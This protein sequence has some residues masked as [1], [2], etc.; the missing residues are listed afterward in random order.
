MPEPRAPMQ[1]EGLPLEALTEFEDNP[2]TITD[3]R[4]D[5]LRASLLALGLFKPLLVWGPE[6]RVVGGNQRLAVLREL[7]REGALPASI[8]PA[9]VPCVRVEVDER[10]ARLVALRDNAPDGDWDW[11]RLPG[12]VEGLAEDFGQEWDVGLMGFDSTV[13]Q[14]LFDL[15][16]DARKAAEAEASAAS[17]AP[18]PPPPPVAQPAAGGEAGPAPAVGAT[19]PEPPDEYVGT[20]FAKVVVGN[21]RGKL[22]IDVYGRWLQVFNGYSERMGTTELP[23]LFAAMVAD[24]ERAH[25]APPPAQAAPS[26]PAQQDAAPATTRR[27]K[28]K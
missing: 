11:E 5:S 17:A 6:N 16:D 15:A 1:I 23:T 8:D 27:R 20:R 25:Q 18:A 12:F 10:T 13:L 19:T 3:A 2:R 9:A 14:D 26:A 4:R 28:A 21:V 24:L 7:A 22:P